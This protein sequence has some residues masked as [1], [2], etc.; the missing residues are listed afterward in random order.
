LLSKQ[1]AVDRQTVWEK[2]LDPPVIAAALLTIPLLV[3]DQSHPTGSWHQ[4]ARFGDWAVWLT[5]LLALAVMLVVTPSPIAYLRKHP[6]DWI[7]VV[8]SPPLLPLGLQWVRVL[9]VLRVVRLLRLGPVLRRVFS[10]E[11]V[12]Y[13]VVLSFVALLGGAAAFSSA[14]K[15]S[16]GTGIYWALGT[17]TTAGSGTIR[18]T[19][20]LARV[21]A[22]VLMIVGPA[23]LALVTGAIA[24]RFLAVKVEPELERVE[25]GEVAMLAQVR[26]L[27]EHVRASNTQ[28]EQLEAALLERQTGA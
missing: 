28:I 16:Y 8:A 6:L 2:R 22:C 25:T 27:A 9:R 7:V 3:L 23:F 26:A 14:E 19:T 15:A 20:S 17:M 24:Q 11:G 4:V 13:A 1:T 12:E 21:V 5:F 10:L 18:A